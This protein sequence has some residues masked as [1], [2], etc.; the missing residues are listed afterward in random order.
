VFIIVTCI[1]SSDLIVLLSHQFSTESPSPTRRSSDLGTNYSVL[2]WQISVPCVINHP[3]AIFCTS[4]SAFNLWPKRF[5]MRAGNRCL[6]M[7]FFTCEM[8]V[9]R[10]ECHGRSV[11]LVFSSLP[12]KFILPEHTDFIKISIKYYDY[13]CIF[14]FIARQANCIRIATDYVRSSMGRLVVR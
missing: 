9:N 3:V 10:P 12:T 1:N 14:A 13:V 2:W 5:C 11:I 7:A 4:R 8:R 6:F